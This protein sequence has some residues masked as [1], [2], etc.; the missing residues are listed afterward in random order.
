MT[1]AGRG[2][3]TEMGAVL[4]GM[5][6]DGA[7]P[8]ILLRAN[9]STVRRSIGTSLA[10]ALVSVGAAE[11]RAH[12]TWTVFSLSVKRTEPAAVRRDHP[13]GTRTVKCPPLERYATNCVLSGM[14]PGGL[15]STGTGDCTGTAPCVGDVVLAC[16]VRPVVDGV[17]TLVDPDVEVQAA[18]SN[19]RVVMTT[20]A[21][22]LLRMGTPFVSVVLT[23]EASRSRRLR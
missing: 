6:H 11:A 20:P 21:N 23:S 8:M 17:C 9:A 19:R 13:S 22:A 3:A 12:V 14:S 16:G 1:T 15:L 5:V 10:L 7:H 4:Y 18:A 2:R